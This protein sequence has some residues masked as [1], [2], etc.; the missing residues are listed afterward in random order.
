M[1]PHRLFF[2]APSSFR[3]SFVTF[4]NA[5]TERGYS[6]WAMIETKNDI[7]NALASRPGSAAEWLLACVKKP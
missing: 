7:L 2:V 5:P 3:N 1:W 4:E 6:G